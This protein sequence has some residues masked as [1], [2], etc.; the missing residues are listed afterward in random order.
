MNVFNFV[1]VPEAN[2]SFSQQYR[3]WNYLA[4]RRFTDG[5]FTAP[6]FGECVLE[7]FSSRSAQTRQSRPV[8]LTFWQLSV[9]VH[10]LRSA[11]HYQ[12]LSF[13]PTLHLRRQC[14]SDPVDP[15]RTKPK[16]KA[17]HTNAKSQFRLV[18]WESEFGSSCFDKVRA[19]KR[20]IGG[21]F[22]KGNVHHD[23]MAFFVDFVAN[24]T[25]LS[26]DVRSFSHTFFSRLVL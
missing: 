4:W 15:Q 3:V 2:H 16:L 6:Q 22:D 14:G 23:A 13:N 10:W 11:K 18:V 24:Q 19:N 9:W 21:Y 1:D 8:S 12:Q 25:T 7:T 5:L 26:N 20:S 17:C